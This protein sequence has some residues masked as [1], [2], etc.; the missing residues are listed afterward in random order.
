VTPELFD[1]VQRVLAVH[2]GGGTRQRVHDHYLKGLLWCGRCGRRFIIMPGRGNGGTYFYFICRGRQGGGCT[3]PY[4]RIEAMEVAVARHYATVR[5]TDDFQASVRSELDDALLGK[6]GGLDALKKR[7]TARLSELDTKEDQFLEL[8]GDP[9]WPRDKIRRK[10]DAIRVERAEITAQLTD[11]TARLAAGREFFL[12]ALALLKDPQGFYKGGGTS[13]KRAMN[14]LIFAKLYVNGD[15]IIS[16]ELGEAVRDVLEAARLR[17]RS[18]VRAGPG[19]LDTPTAIPPADASSP[20][21]GDGAAWASLTGAELLDLALSG[22]GS[23]RAALVGDTGIEPVTSSVSGKRSPAELIAPGLTEVETGFEP[24]Y[25]ALQ[26]V[27]SPLGHSTEE[28]RLWRPRADDGTRTRDPHLGKVMRY[29]LRY[30]R[31]AVAGFTPATDENSSRGLHPLTNRIPGAPALPPSRGH[32]RPP[33]PAP[34]PAPAPACHH[35]RRQ[36]RQPIVE[37]R[38]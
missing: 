19:R 7:L 36:T 23:S 22:Q 31:T 15:E 21:E 6:L 29:Q 12:A 4:L 25:T 13:L 33:P 10:V 38:R 2:G 11:T 17:V 32:R 9:S 24:V 14:K 35:H 26:A 5:L 27:A 18:D 37:P 8:V 30:V 3:Q 20:V 1:R 16:D 34:A 28:V